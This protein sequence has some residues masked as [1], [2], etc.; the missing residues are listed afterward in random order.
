MTVFGLLAGMEVSMPL[1]IV[2]LLW[3][4][5]FGEAQCDAAEP[6]H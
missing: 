2:Q 5:D 4:H 3:Y 1:G 6:V